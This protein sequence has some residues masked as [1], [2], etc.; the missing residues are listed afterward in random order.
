[1]DVP[2]RDSTLTGMFG[3]FR[4]P[5]RFGRSFNDAETDIV[6]IDLAVGMKTC[7]DDEENEG[8]VNEGNENE[9]VGESKKR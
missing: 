7:G 4:Y 8:K 3:F 5:G 2:A 1:M 9:H 6:A